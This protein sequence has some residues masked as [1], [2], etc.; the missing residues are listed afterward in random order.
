VA[1]FFAPLSFFLNSLSFFFNQLETRRIPGSGTAQGAG[2][3]HRTLESAEPRIRRVA[4]GDLEAIR[5]IV[6]WAI[7]HSASNFN[8]LPGSLE[9]WRDDWEAHSTVY[10][11]L[12]SEEPVTDR[13]TGLAY[14]SRYKERSAYDWT[15]E[16]TVYIHPDFHRRGL[17]RALYRELLQTLK[18]QGY[19][20]LIATIALPNPASVGLHESL[21]FEPAG[22]QE[23]VGRKFDR[24]HDVGLWQ[25][26]L[27]SADH[28]PTPVTKLADSDALV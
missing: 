1:K 11:W 20:T 4:L 8:T 24:W 22:I 18:T 28:H 10:P 9:S 2:T 17:G 6:N 13:V 27:R 23:R 21:G 15:S 12:V 7:E 14:A 25:L 5:V 3:E 26:H 16:V 19:H